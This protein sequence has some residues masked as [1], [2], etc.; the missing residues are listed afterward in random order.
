MYPKAREA[1]GGLK[2]G[3]CWVNDNTSVVH[4]V[5]TALLYASADR[6]AFVVCAIEKVAEREKIKAINK[7]DK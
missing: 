2:P 3:V 6:V 5:A 7:P 1:T 4:S